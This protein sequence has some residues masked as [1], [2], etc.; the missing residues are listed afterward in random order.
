MKINWPPFTIIYLTL[1]IAELAAFGPLFW[2]LEWSWAEKLLLFGVTLSASMM[3]ASHGISAL[4]G[5]IE[6]LK[7]GL[8]NFK[9]GDFA[10]QLVYNERDPLGELCQLYNESAEQLRQEKN[11]LHQRELMLDKVLQST[12]EILLLT[13]DHQQVVFSNYAARDFFQSVTKLEGVSLSDLLTH[14]P[15]GAADALIEE[16]YNRPLRRK[17]TKEEAVSE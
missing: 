3:L 10:N 9:D 17:K 14:A 11:W 12:P 2:L 15:S 5:S 7:V 8:L 6:S 13:N 16:T 4:S 1:F